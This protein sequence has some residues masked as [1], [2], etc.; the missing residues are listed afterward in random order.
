MANL[1]ASAIGEFPV[2]RLASGSGGG[3][4][5]G[6]E[7]VECLNAGVGLRALADVGTGAGRECL[8][9]RGV[10]HAQM[11]A[12][13]QAGG[14]VD[15]HRVLSACGEGF[16]NG[17]RAQLTEQAFPFFRRCIQQRGEEVAV[18]PMRHSSGNQRVLDPRPLPG[19][20]GVVREVHRGEREERRVALGGLE[21]AELFG[22]V[23]G[24]SGLGA[25]DL[26]DNAALSVHASV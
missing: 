4:V 20:Q 5:S 12:Q 11:F 7:V 23:H 22:E 13:G 6:E 14:F 2:Q 21:D 9:A 18:A 8:P 3:L 25:A 17:E 1:G 26:C 10:G 16:D 15:V 19:R 24:G